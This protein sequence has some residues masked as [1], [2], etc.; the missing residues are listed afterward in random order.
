MMSLQEIILH[1]T[2]V[3]GLGPLAL[4]KLVDTIGIDQLDTMYKLSCDDFQALG[5][6]VEV[7]QAIVSGLSDRSKLDREL[8]YNASISCWCCNPLVSRISKNS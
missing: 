2:F 8:E 3:E 7:G 5:L 1:L 4:Q 6:S